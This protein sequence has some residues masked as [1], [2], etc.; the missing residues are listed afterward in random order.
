MS[1][2]IVLFQHHLEELRQLLFDRPGIEGGAFMLCGQSRTQ[3]VEKLLSHRVVAI[4]EEDYLRRE[5][6]ALSIHSRA[7]TRIAKLARHEQLSIVFAHSH[8]QGVPHFSAQDDREEDKLIPFFQSRI[9]DRLHGTLV[10][11]EGFI[12][13]RLY[14]PGRT[15]VN[16]ILVVG[17]RIR[18]WSED[19]VEVTSEIFDRQVRAFGPEVQAVLRSLHVG[20]V[21][22]GGT[23]SPLAEQLYRLG[24]G[25]LT[26]FDGDKLESS[27]VTRVY[28]SSLKDEG[29][30]KVAILK[31]HLDRIGFPT[32]VEAVAEHITSEASAKRMRE[33]DV[34]FGCT[35]KQIPRAVLT[36]L[37]IKYL[38]PVFDLG[39]LIDSENETIKGVHGRVTTLLP[40]EACLFCR[41]RISSEAMRI[42]ALPAAER[43]RQVREGYAPELEE[44]APAVIAFTSATASAAVSEL[45]HRITGFMG[46][47]RLSSEVLYR[48]DESRIR[49]NRVSPHPDCLCADRM[50]W[51][52]GDE[53][54]FLGLMWPTT[55]TT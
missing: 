7:L 15:A 4:A 29:D 14:R 8:P 49:T 21:G 25:A 46:R 31:R 33:C 52:R 17:E 22:A 27:N 18:V 48:F 32:T 37:A 26:L 19:R 24:I 40:G 3:G 35:D 55:H 41:R 30:P 54:P 5:R 45:L 6:D 47:E 44:S 53:E 20:I 50:G 42:E 11:T 51:G 28:G 10:L 16:Q 13:G 36:Q 43:A 9:P 39:V 12:A 23:G 1:T 34:V 38:V 2:K